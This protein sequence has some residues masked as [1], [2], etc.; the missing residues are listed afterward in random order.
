MPLVPRALAAALSHNNLLSD[1]E[2]HSINALISTCQKDLGRI[3]P[4]IAH[5]QAVLDGL[6]LRRKNLV[7]Q[8]CSCRSAIAPHRKFPNEILA[9]IFIHSAPE[10]VPILASEGFTERSAPYNIL[11]VCSKC[12]GVALE[13]RGCGIPWK[14]ISITMGT[15]IFVT[16][17]KV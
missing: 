3:D 1:V 10:K 15:S 16:L 9:R 13:I 11:L 12:K 7:A 5:V 4:E 17:P 14:Q 6:L 8:I 2:R